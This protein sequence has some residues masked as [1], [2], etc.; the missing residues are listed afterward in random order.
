MRRPTRAE[1]GAF[2]ATLAFPF[3]A[4]AWGLSSFGCAV[5]MLLLLVGLALSGFSV[6]VMT[7]FGVA[8]LAWT[9]LAGVLGTWNF[10][11]FLR[12]FG[13]ESG[14]RD[15]ALVALNSAF[16]CATNPVVWMGA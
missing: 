12:W 13:D 1:L 15:L 5:W 10:S 6:F 2:G 9:I 11:R 7:P 3:V 4:L 14:A 8:I 16:L